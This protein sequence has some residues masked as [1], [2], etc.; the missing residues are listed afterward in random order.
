MV[1]ESVLVEGC[2][3]LHPSVKQIVKKRV[4]GWGSGSTPS[5]CSTFETMAAAVV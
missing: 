3:D 4:L 2:A 1:L 5:S